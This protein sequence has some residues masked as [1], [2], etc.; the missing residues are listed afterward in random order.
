MDASES[1]EPSMID[2]RLDL[3]SSLTPK[4]TVADVLGHSKVRLQSEPRAIALNS[5]STTF[6]NHIFGTPSVEC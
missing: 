2:A 6:P 1:E 3:S 4:I 5:M